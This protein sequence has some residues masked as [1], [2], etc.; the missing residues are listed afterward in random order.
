MSRRHQ[1]ASSK[2]GDAV[3]RFKWE[4]MEEL[5][6]ADKGRQPST[7]SSQRMEML[8]HLYR[9]PVKT[10]GL[11]EVQKQ[12]AWGSGKKDDEHGEGP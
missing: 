10:P 11:T 6:L 1:R 8:D 12:V 9:E 5:G 4:I 7:I 2:K 3:D